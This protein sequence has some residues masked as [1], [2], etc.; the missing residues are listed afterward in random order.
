LNASM[1]SSRSWSQIS[2][3]RWIAP[4]IS[5]RRSCPHVYVSPEGRFEA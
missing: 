1:L 3:E 4:V 5:S 2:F